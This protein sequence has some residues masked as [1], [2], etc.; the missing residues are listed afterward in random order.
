MGKVYV[1]TSR[2]GSRQGS[3]QERCTDHF[4][5]RKSL[6]EFMMKSFAHTRMRFAYIAHF[7]KNP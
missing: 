2:K 4:Y 1:Q 6:G 7:D 5:G 3:R